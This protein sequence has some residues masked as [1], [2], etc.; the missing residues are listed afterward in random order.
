M[1]KK[2]GR[3]HLCTEAFQKVQFIDVKNSYLRG[4]VF[5]K[6]KKSKIWVKYSVNF[7]KAVDSGVK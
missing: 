2:I 1:C 4:V 3:G 5:K 6:T 7:S